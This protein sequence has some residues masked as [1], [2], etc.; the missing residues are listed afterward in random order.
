MFKCLCVNKVIIPIWKG[1]LKPLPS[2]L[3][4]NSAVS[5]KTDSWRSRQGTQGRQRRRAGDSGREL[6]W[7]QVR[8]RRTVTEH[9]WSRDR[10]RATAK[11]KGWCA[12]CLGL[13]DGPGG[14]LC[15]C[16]CVTTGFAGIDCCV[17]SVRSLQ[18]LA[19]V[20]ES[21]PIFAWTLSTYLCCILHIV[22]LSLIAAVA[23]ATSQAAYE[24]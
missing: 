2:S 14:G 9:L 20:V 4:S 19:K 5:A 13:S 7:T 1:F 6:R 23:E 24:L 21:G 8:W 18:V 22:E 3:H 11:T 17:D 16:M 15:V 12:R 10:Q